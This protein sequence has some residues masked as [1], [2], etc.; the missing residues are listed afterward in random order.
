MGGVRKTVILKKAEN[1]MVFKGRRDAG[2]AVSFYLYS[3]FISSSN[4]IKPMPSY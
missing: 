1:L 2:H 4:G 3:C